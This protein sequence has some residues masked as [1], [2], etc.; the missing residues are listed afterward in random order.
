M[1]ARPDY[2]IAREIAGFDWSASGSQ[3]ALRRLTGIP[4]KAFN[5][6]PDAC[7]ETYRRGRP[8]ITEMFGPDVKPPGLTTPAVS[9]GHVNGL[10]AE[11]IFPEDGE[12]SFTP[13]YSSLDQGIEALRKD[14]DFASAGMAPFFVD[15]R[16]KLQDA[17]PGE[18]VS[19]SYGMEGPI[20]TA[21]ELRGADFFTDI[22]DSPEKTRE[23]LGLC[24]KSLIEFFAFYNRVKDV[25]IP[26]PTSGGLA[27]DIASMIAPALWPEFVMPFL[28]DYYTGITTSRRTAHIEDLRPEH[29][30]YL[31][32]IGLSSYD[33]SI[34]P[35][36][37]PRIIFRECRV[38]F[39]WR[40]GCFYCRDM[41]VGNIEDFVF[42]AAADGASSVHTIVSG[43]LCNSEG[44]EKTHAF[45][46]AAKKAKEVL[47]SGAQRQN[48]L[49]LVSTEGRK[50]SFPYSP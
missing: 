19:F 4:I 33:P 10:G 6:E 20:T 43:E 26:S 46:R 42:L 50:R 41:S 21:W 3:D 28:E 15:F 25:P 44:V 30:K 8:L 34:S 48:L 39:T 5:L 14:V 49:D 7:I 24:V 23:F 29:L 40:L 37:N 27:D 36:I 31:E 32:E 12:V 22:Y 13:L 17:F 11:L 47:D 38:P 35:K 1:Y 45:I 2:N 16:K 18:Y 9:Y